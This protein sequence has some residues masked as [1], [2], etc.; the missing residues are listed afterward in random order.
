MYER[1]S[2]L[3]DVLGYLQWE[4][5]KIRL[6]TMLPSAPFHYKDACSSG[7]EVARGASTPAF[8]F[9]A[10]YGDDGVRRT[11]A[12]DGKRARSQCI[13]RFVNPLRK[14]QEA[15]HRSGSVSSRVRFKEEDWSDDETRMRSL[16]RATYL[17]DVLLGWFQRIIKVLEMKIQG[18]SGKRLMSARQCV[19]ETRCLQTCWDWA[20][21][22]VAGFRA[23]NVEGKTKVPPS[24]DF[25]RSV[26]DRI[27]RPDDESSDPGGW[28]FSRKS[29]Q[30]DHQSGSP[31]APPD[32]PDESDA[33][34]SQ[35]PS[36]DNGISV[37]DDDSEE[38][39][40][41][42]SPPIPKHAPSTAQDMSAIAG[43]DLAD[44][45][46]T[47]LPMVTT[48]PTDYWESW[49]RA[50]TVVYNWVLESEPG[51]V[52]RDNAL[53]WELLLHKMLLRRSSKS[54]GKQRISKDTLAARFNA[55]AQGDYQFLVKGLVKACA[56]A[57]RR[58]TNYRPNDEKTIQSRVE[59]LLSMGRFSKAFRLLDSKGQADMGDQGVIRQLDEKHG[60]RMHQLPG[61]LPPDMPRAKFAVKSFKQRYRMLKPLSGVGPDGYRYE[62]LSCL[63]S[64]MSCPLASAAVLRH[65]DFAESFV[66]AD[67]PA[68]YYWVATATK[69]IAL[70]KSQADTEG[71]TPDVR[72]IGMGGCKRRAWTS[73]LMKDNKDTFKATFWSAQVAIGVEA[74][75]IKLV[76]GTTEHMRHNKQHVL[77]KLDFSNAFNTVWRKAVL[78]ACRDKQEW[79][80]LYRFF[81]CTLSPKSM[82]CGINNLS[83]EGMQQG[84]SAGS[85][86]FCMPLQPQAEWVNTQLQK[87]G[88]RAVFDM[89]DGY[90]LG[91]IEHVMP[92]VK[93]FQRRLA[94]HVGADLNPSK[95]QLW[96]HKE[97][98][99]HVRAYLDET[100][101][102]EFKLGVV[103]LA[104]GRKAYGVK[105]SGVP[106]GDANYVKQCLK[107]KV[108]EVVS[109]V[110]STTK[111]LQRHSAQNLFALLVQCLH[112]KLQFWL[113]CMR[114]EQL[115][116][117]LIKFDKVMLKAARTATGQ[118]FPEQSLSLRRL[119]LPRR[120][121]GGMV[122]SAKDL[123]RAAYVGGICQC[124]P[125]F[126]KSIDS[127]GVESEG[128]L[129][130]LS[131]LYGKGSFDAGAETTRFKALLEGGSI[132]GEDLRKH[133]VH[134]CREAH[135]DID[136]ADMEDTSPFKL[137][138][139]GAGIVK[140]KV[141]CKAQH[142]FTR[143]RENARATQIMEALRVK[144][145]AKDAT[146]S[147]EE[148]AFLS[149]NRLSVQ[150]VGVPK[151][152]RTVMD[153]TTFHEAWSVYMGTA[154]PMCKKWVG[155]KFVDVF[156]RKRVVDIH[157]D[158][159]GA[160]MLPG[161][162]WRTRH[163]A[164][165]WLLAQ[166]ASWAM[167]QVQV[168]P[169]N[170]FLPWIQ[171]KEVFLREQ[172]A[173]KRQ[174]MIP[175]FLDIKRQAMLD[176]KGCSFCKTRYSAARFRNAQTCNA[177]LLRQMQV[178]KDAIR[179]AEKIDTMYNSWDKSSG[180]PGPMSQR[181]SNF[182]RVE[183]LV[184]GAHGEGSPDML[185][186]IA[187]IADRA[188]QT[189]YRVMGF[190]SARSAR[191]TVLNQIYLSI[192]IEAV[193]GMARLRIA[194]LG[195][196]LA[197]S[198]STKA[199]T[200]RRNRARH[201]YYE[202]CQAYFA[203][204]CYYDI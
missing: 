173:R 124:V 95:C 139:E 126:T 16:L 192:G 176:V 144:L 169:N 143:A 108:G 29:D 105:I 11:L 133:F 125:S 175:D 65:R 31:P 81:W 82:I 92:L 27:A 178:H 198:T 129:D 56:A 118:D 25:L 150:F 168:E 53:F 115:D 197:G 159:V 177:V 106:F 141:V 156:K 58:K 166:Q 18:H 7:N 123:A 109:Q 149:I 87:V 167:Y 3:H 145:S 186:F 138:P 187:R 122:R 68:W 4:Y 33:S 131:H 54:R 130:H 102:T 40:R 101:E 148:A 160:A 181:L 10:I 137:G 77:L 91:P 12:I 180:S 196:A 22:L 99:Q 200:A 157:G 163:D 90:L 171:Q 41:R 34:P 17:T 110:K 114:P 38:A 136:R 26:I 79:R 75:V 63:G 72:P 195:A 204:Q 94:D 194:N 46:F 107:V 13:A 191:S 44:L 6:L 78:Q 179:R 161:D 184:V 21:G 1:P 202:Q 15:F 152:Y 158:N 140:G 121:G 5:D 71:G 8:C 98:R 135:G 116:S 83:C 146:P 23:V 85:T 182:G 70:I 14:M 66:N 67:L 153:N 20:K 76:F 185:K 51:S 55:F 47:E 151:M 28:R 60:P 50:N 89:D 170:I 59:K 113:Q 57:K 32:P 154:S 64:T 52:D 45:F 147:R 48:V 9:A 162:G 183:G 97:H 117:H 24:I 74:G 49:A 142:A 104:N 165:K 203:R 37:Q 155:T 93:V 42:E 193:R 189:R 19:P 134:M 128:F 2:R 132:L 103:T 61:T 100:G 120:L 127:D 199:A 172:N 188:A 80:H 88:G 69:M 43:V 36:E 30:F 164:L 119:R 111:R 201:L 112:S 96:C 35:T 62:Y 86:G 73:C 174:G 190:S 39:R 84:D